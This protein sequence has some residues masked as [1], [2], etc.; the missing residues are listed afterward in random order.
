MPIYGD[1][2]H[3]EYAWKFINHG[4]YSVKSPSMLWMI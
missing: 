2:D 4:E 3:H 1:I